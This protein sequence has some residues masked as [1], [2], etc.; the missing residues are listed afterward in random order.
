MLS[1]IA[2]TFLQDTLILSQSNLS[3]EER[4]AASRC[5]EYYVGA[6]EGNVIYEHAVMIL[7]NQGHGKA[8]NL[9]IREIGP[10]NAVLNLDVPG[11]HGAPVTREA[12]YWPGDV[13]CSGNLNIGH[14][15]VGGRLSVEKSLTLDTASFLVGEVS[16]KGSCDKHNPIVLGAGWPKVVESQQLASSGTTESDEGLSPSF[17]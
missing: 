15:A 11:R 9:L 3:A 8:A 6:K 1:P 7:G 12:L 17:G 5:I 4:S 2:R 13:Q 14:G 16:F 10:T